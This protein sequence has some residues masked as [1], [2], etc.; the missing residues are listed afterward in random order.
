[1]PRDAVIGL[2]VLAVA[3]LYYLAAGT[4]RRS[5]L[6]DAVGAAGVPNVLAALLAGLAVLMILRS[7]LAPRLAT[8]REARRGGEEA[9]R[10]HLRAFGMLGLGIAYLL[11]TPILGYAVSVALLIA[12]VAIYNY[13]KP[14]PGL[15]LFA[16]G[17]AACF[18]VLFV[19][20]LSIP[21]P[22]GIWP[23]LLPL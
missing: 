20:V 15:A 18:Y 19:W 4:I 2:F 17:A 12:A 10:A 14:T 11:V 6:E 16:V 13:R 1:M 22:P 5:S 3:G 7:V 9:P 23:A 8:A 21:L